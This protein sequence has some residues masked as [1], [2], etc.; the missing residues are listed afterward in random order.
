M[1]VSVLAIFPKLI[2]SCSSDDQSG[3][4]LHTIRS[5]IRIFEVLFETFKIPLNTHIRQIRHHMSNDFIRTV[6]GQ[7][8]CFLNSLDCMSSVG[9]SCYIFIDG[10][11]TNLD[12]GTAIR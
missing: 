1:V 4:D 10:L 2:K 9:I 5:E 6:F 3:I 8:K 7:G 11:H 12:S